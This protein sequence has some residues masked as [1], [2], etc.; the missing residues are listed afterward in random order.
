[1][2]SLRFVFDAAAKCG[3]KDSA[4]E[5][6][7]GLLVALLRLAMIIAITW[8]VCKWLCL[9]LFIDGASMEPTYS[10]K[11]FNFC[12]TLAYAF[13][14]PKAGD[15]VVVRYGGTSTMLLKRVVATE[16]QSVEFRKGRL[17]VD[18]REVEEPYVKGPCDWELEPRPVS[19]G[20]IYVI[21][22]NRSMP[23]E[24]HRFG[25]VSL[26]KVEGAPLW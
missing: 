1:M 11:G 26:K 20:H 10:S 13:S 5:K 16:G 25:E 8:S 21:G 12:W 14:K 4:P 18:G 7:G 9:P 23:I 17:L 6:G 22:D 3:K 19:K 15:I 2:N 24:R